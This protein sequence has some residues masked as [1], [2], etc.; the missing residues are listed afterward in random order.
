MAQKFM[1]TSE[2]YVASTNGLSF[3]GLSWFAMWLNVL[4]DQHNQQRTCSKTN[5]LHLRV[6]T[7]VTSVLD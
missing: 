2:V 1:A 4:M 6:L 3:A 5:W 7:G